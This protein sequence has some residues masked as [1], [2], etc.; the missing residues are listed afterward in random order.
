[1]LSPRILLSFYEQ[2]FS[3]VKFSIVSIIRFVCESSPILW[4]L[5]IKGSGPDGN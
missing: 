3:P 2:L 4:K 5:N 1:M